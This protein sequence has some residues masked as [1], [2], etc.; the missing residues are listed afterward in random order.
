M[1][2]STAKQIFLSASAL[3]IIFLSCRPAAYEIIKP[4]KGTPVEEASGPNKIAPDLNQKPADQL[5]TNTGNLPPTA[6]LEAVV[7]GRSVVKVRVNQQVNFRPSWDTL[8]PDYLGRTSCVNAGIAKASYDLGDE[9]HPVVERGSECLSLTTDFGFQR[10]GDYLIKL[11]VTSLDQQTAYASMIL[12]VLAPEAPITDA[13]GFTIKADTLLPTKG[14]VVTFTGRCDLPGPY[15]ISWDF[16]EGTRAEGPKVVHA[17]QALGQFQVSAVCVGENGARKTA[18]LTLVVVGT[19]MPL[20]PPAVIPPEEGTN[21]VPPL[22]SPG[23]KEPP[24]QNG[25]PFQQIPGQGSWNQCFE[26]S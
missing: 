25:S 4:K 20:P 12:T 2:P 15:T 6:R 22:P 26:P 3:A 17:Y 21:A 13:G 10:P 9:A 1:I 16:G 11:T 14:Q 7:S 23:P 18:S 24:V 19:P 8:D 5:P